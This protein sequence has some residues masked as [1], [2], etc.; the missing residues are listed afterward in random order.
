VDGFRV[1]AVSET[2]DE[3]VLEIETTAIAVGRR[4]AGLGG[5]RTSG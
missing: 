1:L 5:W 2:G 3:L 4:G